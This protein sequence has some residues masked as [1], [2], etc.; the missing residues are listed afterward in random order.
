M[1]Q[2]LL[3]GFQMHVSFFKLI[4]K[5]DVSLPADGPLK[6]KKMGQKKKK[7]NVVGLTP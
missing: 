1:P 6:G 3:K 4:L 2:V 5:S 7:V